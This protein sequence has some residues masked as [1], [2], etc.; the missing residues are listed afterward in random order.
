HQSWQSALKSVS[1]L[2]EIWQERHEE[3]KHI[4]LTSSA[5]SRTAN[6][7]YKLAELPEH[8]ALWDE[9][10]SAKEFEGDPRQLQMLS[11]AHLQEN[12]KPK[13]KGTDP[14][15]FDP[16]FTDCESVLQVTDQI[17]SAF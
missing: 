14:D 10:F 2:A 4:L 13:Q 8:F 7:G 11:A 9:I 5:I 15:L 1:R 17:R 6:N 12:S 3:L 16:F